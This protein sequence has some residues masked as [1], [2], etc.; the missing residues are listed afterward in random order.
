MKIK[1]LFRRPY[2]YWITGIFLTYMLTNIL[3]SGFYKTMQLIFIYAGTVNWVELGI[4]IVFSLT[5]GILVAINAVYGYLLY[6]E[7]KK[8]LEGNVL[9]GAG[10][11]GGITAGICPLCVTGLLPIIFGLFGLS[12]SFASL[13]F[14]GL[15]IQ[16]AVIFI[17][18]MSL[19]LLNR[20]V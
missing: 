20:K 3:I 1:E 5:I 19:V 7:R 15:E 14:K 12:F 11:L 10:T 16:L 8:C 9:A 13:P 4:S 6:K 17:L 2:I 18:I